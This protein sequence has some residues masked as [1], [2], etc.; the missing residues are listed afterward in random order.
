MPPPPLKKKSKTKTYTTN[1]ILDDSAIKFSLNLHSP[2]QPD[3]VDQTKDQ[4]E[5]KRPTSC[6]PTKWME[7]TKL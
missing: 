1:L 3:L 4:R 2:E 7:I 5:W 6:P